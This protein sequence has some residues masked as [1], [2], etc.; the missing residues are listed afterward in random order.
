[1][2]AVI[3]AGGFGTRIAEESAVRPKPMV[4]VG[5]RPIL[6]HIMKIYSAFDVTDFV[7][8]A[9]YKGDVIREFFAN[10]ALH[11]SDV[12]F[13]L[14][15][16]TVELHSRYSEPWRVT[17]LD[18]GEDTL[19]AG[20][21]M[22]A[23]DHLADETFFLTYGDCVSNV[24]M[25]ELLR[26]H[27]ACGALVTLTAVQP[28][29]RFGVLALDSGQSMVT[30]FREKPV[31]DGAWMNGGFFVVEPDALAR[32]PTPSDREPW[33]RTTLARIAKEGRLA[34]YRHTGY[35]QNLDTLRDKMILEKHWANDPQWR[36]W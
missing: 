11:T 23:R 25:H 28:P 3:F 13:D 35:W 4:E 5:G 31:G 8:L 36:L 18:T 33:E 6:W 17:I 16:N 7:I 27:R 15:S 21:L 19:T 29:G 30:E 2:K 24:D 32:I 22:A 26:F 12:T 34:A 1:M 14:A 10:Y 9:G 20:R